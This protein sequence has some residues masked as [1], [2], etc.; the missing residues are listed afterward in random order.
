MNF[1]PLNDTFRSLKFTHLDQPKKIEKGII[2][3]IEKAFGELMIN[4]VGK[5]NSRWESQ[6]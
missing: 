5:K 3:A 6:Q 1:P 4:M 2:P